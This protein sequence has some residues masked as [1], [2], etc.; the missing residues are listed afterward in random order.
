[1]YVCLYPSALLCLTVS[2]F[3]CLPVLLLH[4]MEMLKPVIMALK[5]RETE[6][7]IHFTCCLNGGEGGYFLKAK[8]C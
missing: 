3:L 2:L 1:M 7:A 4:V 5:L 6:C 8:E